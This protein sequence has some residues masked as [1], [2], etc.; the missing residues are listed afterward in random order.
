MPKLIFK[1]FQLLQ[2]NFIKNKG[3]SFF[4]KLKHLDLNYKLI[5]YN[6]LICLNKSIFSFKVQRSER[7]S[8]IF[9]LINI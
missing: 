5:P 8:T 7:L 1:V 6:S 9:K 2:F 4:D 3:I